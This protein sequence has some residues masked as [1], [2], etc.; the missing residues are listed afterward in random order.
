[1]VCRA[2]V[3]RSPFA[4]ELMRCRL[5]AAGRSDI[6]VSSAGVRAAEGM[7]LCSNAATMLGGQDGFDSWPADRRSRRLDRDMIEQSDLILTA[8]V[9]QRSAVAVLHPVARHR[10]FTLMEAAVILRQLSLKNENNEAGLLASDRPLSELT[11]Q[12]YALR[13]SL[14]L[15]IPDSRAILRS[16]RSLDVQMNEWDIGDGHTNGGRAHRRTLRQV[17]DA[18]LDIAAALAQLE[19][20]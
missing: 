6:T 4:E 20:Q 7:A 12:M 5:S 8:S 13:G 2:N 1:M 15:V 10:A 14:P 18:S 16:I 17:H 19:V 9:E 11:A 3:C